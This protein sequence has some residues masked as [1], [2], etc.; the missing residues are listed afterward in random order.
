[1]V[2]FT[3]LQFMTYVT[4]MPAE[5][6]LSEQR[7][8]KIIRQHDREN[9]HNFSKETNIYKLQQHLATF[10]WPWQCKRLLKIVHPT[11]SSTHYYLTKFCDRQFSYILMNRDFIIWTS[12][13]SFLPI[14]WPWPLGYN[15]HKHN[16]WNATSFSQIPPLMMTLVSTEA[17]R[18]PSDILWAANYLWP[19]PSGKVTKMSMSW[20]LISKKLLWKD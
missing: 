10:L 14:L 3:R 11:V 12:Y 19:R 7:F 6:H 18:T 9:L 15:A 17:P 16:F 20:T 2:L 4:L 5:G 8:L 13:S 1:M